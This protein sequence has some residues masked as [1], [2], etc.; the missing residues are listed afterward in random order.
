MCFI[1][2]YTTQKA[3]GYNFFNFHTYETSII[4]ICKRSLYISLISIN[5]C[6][7]AT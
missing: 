3:I 6:I 7:F 5:K 4:N 2:K 1:A